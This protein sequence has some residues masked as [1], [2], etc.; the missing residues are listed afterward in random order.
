MCTLTVDKAANWIAEKYMNWQDPT[1]DTEAVA[2]ATKYNVLTIAFNAS[3]ALVVMAVACAIL[4]SPTA[5]LVYGTIGL[6]VRSVVK[7]ELDTYSAP[8][9]GRAQEA[10]LDKRILTK[11]GIRRE[12][13]AADE[14]N[15]F[16][17]IVWKN[18]V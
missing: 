14:V 7:E 16:N 15:L 1:M 2:P 5:A 17:V 4:F 13:W 10:S 9:S 8:L 3:T 12:G 6:A 11:L 18:L